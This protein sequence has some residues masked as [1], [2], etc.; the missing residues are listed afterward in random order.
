MSWR[1]YRNFTYWKREIFLDLCNLVADGKLD[2]FYGG[3]QSEFPHDMVFVRFNS[4]DTDFKLVADLF[5]DQSF[6]IQ[7]QHFYFAG[8]K[9]FV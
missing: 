6:D 5:I 1:Q 2:H 7:F 4:P 9:E 8:G 3:L